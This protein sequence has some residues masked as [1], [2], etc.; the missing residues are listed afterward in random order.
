MTG[1][2]FIVLADKLSPCLEACG[3]EPRWPQFRTKVRS[4][5]TAVLRLILAD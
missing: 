5:A 1:E 3:S 4:Y 2:D